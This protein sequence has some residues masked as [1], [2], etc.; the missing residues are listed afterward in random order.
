MD[1]RTQ[2]MRKVTHHGGSSGRP[3]QCARTYK[4]CSVDLFLEYL[5]ANFLHKLCSRCYYFD[6][7]CKV[8]KTRFFEV[9]NCSLDTTKTSFSN[10]YGVGYKR[11]TTWPLLGGDP[12]VC[13]GPHRQP[14]TRF[15]SSRLRLH[16]FISVSLYE[17][18]MLSKIT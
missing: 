6:S 7:C 13:Q 15:V 3:Q 17:N 4:R 2:Q 12:M 16:A 5:E 11:T 10:K 1:P 8:S 14:K 18:F 9:K